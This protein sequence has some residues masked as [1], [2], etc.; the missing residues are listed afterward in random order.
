MKKKKHIAQPLEFGFTKD[1]F[2]LESQKTEDGQRTQEEIDV[3][4]A[5][6]IL[7]TKMQRRFNL[8]LDKDKWRT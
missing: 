4:R 3:A 6:M 8:P 2:N 1:T 7:R 5:A